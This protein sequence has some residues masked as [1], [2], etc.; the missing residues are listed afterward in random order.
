M[1]RR[2]F[3]K[4]LAGVVPAGMLGLE[5]ALKQPER[6]PVQIS[7]VWI[8]PAEKPYSVMAFVNESPLHQKRSFEDFQAMQREKEDELRSG[9][10]SYFED[11]AWQVPGE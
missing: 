7:E 1:N 9:V 8:P 11:Q 10:A 6:L 3:L 4:A 5:L 2:S